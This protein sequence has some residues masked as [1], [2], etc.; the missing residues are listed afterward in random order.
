MLGRSYR[1]T[2]IVDACTAE[3]AADAPAASVLTESVA[4]GLMHPQAVP[5]VLEYFHWIA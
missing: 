2:L 1:N 3:I 5:T 4:A